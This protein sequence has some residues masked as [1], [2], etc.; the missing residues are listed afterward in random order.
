[1]WFRRTS[2]ARS[3]LLLLDLTQS[4]PKPELIVSGLPEFELVAIG[5]EGAT[6]ADTEIVVPAMSEY[7]GHVELLL[8]RTAPSMTFKSGQYD[9]IFEEQGQKHAE[10]A[11]RATLVETAVPR[12]K[13]LASRG[14]DRRLVLRSSSSSKPAKISVV[15]AKRCEQQ[16]LC[17]N[18]EAIAGTPFLRVLVE[19]SCGDA[20][21]VRWQLYDPETQEFIDFKSQR[22]SRQ[23]LDGRDVGD[24][25]DAFVSHGGEGF[26]IDGTV[27]RFDGSRTFAGEGKGGGWLGGQWHVGL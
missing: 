13:E 5:Y 18:A 16:D 14:F 19:H 7:D 10:A 8:G 24:L 12:L 6:N 9:S 3:E 17:G 15:S 20:C 25:R 26:I 4:S 11:S 1:V 27:Y 2:G 23:P 21:H 22:R